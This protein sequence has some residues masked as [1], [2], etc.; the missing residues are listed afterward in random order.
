MGSPTDTS[1]VPT[2]VDLIADAESACSAAPC[3]V[4]TIPTLLHQASAR[5]AVFPAAHP[6]NHGRFAVPARQSESCALNGPSTSA[7][8]M[9]AVPGRRSQIW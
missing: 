9:I 1:R 2:H 3:S 4:L 7:M 6:R 8:K 5:N